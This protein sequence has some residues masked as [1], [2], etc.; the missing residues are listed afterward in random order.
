LRTPLTLAEV[1][2]FYAIVSLAL[3]IN[4]ESMRFLLSLGLYDLFALLLT[5][6]LTFGASFTLS[7]LWVFRKTQPRVAQL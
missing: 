1:V 4:T 2:R 7:K 5:V 3:L 6:G